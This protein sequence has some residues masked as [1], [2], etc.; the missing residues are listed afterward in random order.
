MSLG[1]EDKSVEWN[2]VLVV[3]KQKVEVLESF[4]Y[5]EAFHLVLCSNVVDVLYVSDG[6]VSL[7][8]SRVFFKRLEDR[9]APVLVG[10]VSRQSVEIEETLYRL[11][12]LQIVR[13]GRLT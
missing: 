1:V 9:P 10:F 13:I 2:K 3:G 11:R 12:S 8:Q 4:R 5:P 7:V 6:R